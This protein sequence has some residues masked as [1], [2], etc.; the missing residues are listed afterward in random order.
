[1]RGHVVALTFL[2]PVCTTDCPL[3]AEEF[4][5]ADEQLQAENQKG[6]LR[7]HR[8]E[9]DLP[10]ALLHQRLRPAG[11]S[12]PPAQRYYLTGTTDSCEQVWSS[13]GEFVTPITGGAMVAHSDL[14]FVIDAK[15]RER[16]R[17]D[18]RSG[19]QP[20]IRL[21]LHLTT[22]RSHRPGP[23]VVSSVASGWG[24]SP[25]STRGARHYRAVRPDVRGRRAECHRCGCPPTPSASW[26]GLLLRLVGGAATWTAVGQGEHLLELLHLSA[27]SGSWS[28]ITP[29]GTAD[30]GG[31]VAWG[32]GR[33]CRRRRVAQPSADLLTT[34]DQLG[35]R[36]Q[37][38]S[39]VPP[40]RR[41][42]SSD[43]LALDAAKS[44]NVLAIVGKRVLTSPSAGAN[45]STLV[46]LSTLRRLFPSCGG[47][48]CRRS[49]STPSGVPLVGVQC[50]HGV[51]LFTEVSGSWR[52][53]GPRLGRK[54]GTAPTSFLR[55][56]TTG[57]AITAS[58]AVVGSG[59]TQ[60]VAT[61]Q[62]AGG[63]GTTSPAL[64]VAS[65][66]ASTSIAQSGQ[67]GGARGI[68]ARLR[69]RGG[70][71]GRQVDGAAG[72]ASR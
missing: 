59:H 72:T 32:V 30:N 9:P 67:V 7:R 38:G 55:L 65:G 20:D 46:S 28:S 42:G 56:E 51:G 19:A 16:R 48:G 37:L 24:A 2:D 29:E 57:S 35:Q 69:R 39:G 26:I 60:L 13:Y 71:T 66:P 58:L 27:G 70:H 53:V 43:G 11:G 45:W 12:R 33:D 47:S 40:R 36:R 8:R 34:R 22:A 68:E 14:A 21:V 61:W 5:L 49:R 23:V 64:T 54:L 44:G 3:I 10:V 18:R 25:G 52:H 6:R 17:A 41:R 15:G 31:L 63:R 50:R 1:M 62:A 4:R